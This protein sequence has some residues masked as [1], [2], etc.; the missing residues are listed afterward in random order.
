ME[1]RENQS[2]RE[3]EEVET[4]PLLENRGEN[5]AQHI[6]QELLPQG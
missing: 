2:K 1:C 5:Q 3:G 6:A 4:K